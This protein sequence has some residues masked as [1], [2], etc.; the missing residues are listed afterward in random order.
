MKPLLIVKK[1][2]VYGSI[3]DQGREGYRAF[4]ALRSGPMD[5]VSFQVAHAIVDNATVTK[6]RL[7]CL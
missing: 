3:Q 1:Q 5:K 2:G 4:G 7:K 6:R